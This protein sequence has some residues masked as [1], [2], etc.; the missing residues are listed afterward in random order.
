MWSTFKNRFV[1]HI[2]FLIAR[3]YSF[4]FQP[5]LN[6][7]HTLRLADISSFVAVSNYLYTSNATGF[8][9]QFIWVNYVWFISF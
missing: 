8:S 2:T 5:H 6:W 7:K 9:V 1:M 4:F 3:D